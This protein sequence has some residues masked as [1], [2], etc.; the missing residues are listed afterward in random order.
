[1]ASTMASTSHL[2]L[3]G[4]FN[5]RNSSSSG[6]SSSSSSSS[7]SSSSSSSSS[8]NHTCDLSNPLTETATDPIAGNLTFHQVGTIIAGCA[9]A[10][11]TL[12]ILILMF[13]HATHLSKP[14]E[15]LKIMRICL[16]IPVNAL[17]N[18]I[19]QLVPASYFYIIVWAD[20]MQAF[21]LGNFFLLLL[22]FISPHDHQR[23]FFFSGLQIPRKRSKKA[24]KDGLR[25]YRRKWFAVF[26]YP[27]VQ[28]VVSI[29]TDVT[30]SPHLN[31]YCANTNKPYFAHL[32]LNLFHIL[33][34]IT[35]VM[36]C[37]RFY[38][39]LKAE[40]A[41]HKPLSKLFAFK[42]MVGLNFLMNIVF[43]VLNDINPSPLAP[44]STMSEADAVAGIPAVVNC[45]IMVP[46]SIF[47]HYAY[48]VGPYYIDRTVEAGRRGE[49]DY[50]QY[51]GGFLGIRAFLGMLN[52]GEFFGAV[53]YAFKMS[54]A[55][56]ENGGRKG[57]MQDGTAFDTVTSSESRDL[58]NSHEMSRRDQRRPGQHSRRY[59]HRRDNSA[60]HALVDRTQ[61]GV[62]YNQ[63]HQGRLY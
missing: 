9:A 14:N 42:L 21:A 8:T 48:D 19:G 35:A 28:L 51:Q 2:L 25:W 37:L 24:S 33:S 47:F 27:I 62:G 49:A 32:W 1:M 57:S 39:V 54:R 3:R 7:A 16:L 11:S 22:E 58:G 52:P 46:F 34:L 53:A 20:M 50:L 29:A 55:K 56:R 13:R 36:S 41:G 38:K 15:Q 60:G 6:S 23:D 45:V 4:F 10:F 30:N 12:S 40:L 5:H 31:I 17:F 59:D 61:D 18:L 44:S 26:Q 43:W 63:A